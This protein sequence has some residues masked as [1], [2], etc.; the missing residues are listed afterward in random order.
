MHI[1][2]RSPP[3][4]SMFDS[5]FS[6]MQT[7]YAP[8]EASPGSLTAS[9]RRSIHH[10]SSG[11]ADMA[12]DS[13]GEM[14]PPSPPPPSPL[15]PSASSAAVAAAAAVAEQQRLQQ[16]SDARVARARALLDRGHGGGGTIAASD[17][18]AAAAAPLQQCHGSSTALATL[19]GAEE[20]A[21]AH[22]AAMA[23]APLPSAAVPAFVGWTRNDLSRRYNAAM[24]E[25]RALRARLAAAEATAA[26]ALAEGSRAARL[27]EFRAKHEGAV[28]VAVSSAE[29]RLRYA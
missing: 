26:A 1:C 7:A 14:P 20:G 25:V 22:G 15:A 4:K 27:A 13:E 8:A 6:F 9:T 17:S 29:G 12:V 11:S 23:H 2:K 21:H 3:F 28:E 18:A 24:D 5:A 10:E 19:L 16:R